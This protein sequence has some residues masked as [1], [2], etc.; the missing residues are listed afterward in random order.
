MTSTTCALHA[1]SVATT[2]APD[3]VSAMKMALTAA[4]DRFTMK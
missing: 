3:P 2:I 4:A 1:L